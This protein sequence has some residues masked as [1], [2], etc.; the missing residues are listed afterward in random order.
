M[1]PPSFLPSALAL[2]L[3]LP[4][5]YSFFPHLLVKLVFSRG[6]QDGDANP[7]VW[8][9]CRQRWTEPR[10]GH[11]RTKKQIREKQSKGVTPTGDGEQNIL[12]EAAQSKSDNQTIRQSDNQIRD[13]GQETRDKRHETRDTRQGTIRYQTNRIL[14]EYQCVYLHFI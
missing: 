11:E 7:S 2:S 12:S 10:D 9:H 4:F 14:D 3:V 5:A 8:V 1:I 13:K 6:V